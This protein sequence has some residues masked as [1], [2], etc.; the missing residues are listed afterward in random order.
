MVSTLITEGNVIQ[1][2]LSLILKSV[3]L[4]RSKQGGL[5]F[6]GWPSTLLRAMKQRPPIE[7]EC[8]E[9]GKVLKELRSPNGCRAVKAKVPGYFFVFNIL[10]LEI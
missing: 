1:N 6:N 3:L 5:I 4:S 2:M 10:F 7:V 8:G 9:K